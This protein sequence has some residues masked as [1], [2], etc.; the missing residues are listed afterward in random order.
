M[1]LIVLA[2]HEIHAPRDTRGH[3]QTGES[4]EVIVQSDDLILSTLLVAPTSR[5]APARSF[6]PTITI[7]NEKTQSTC[8]TNLGRCPRTARRLCGPRH[9]RRTQRNQRR[10]STCTRTR[11]TPQVPHPVPD[12]RRCEGLA[13]SKMDGMISDR[14]VSL[15]GKCLMTGSASLGAK[16]LSL[17]SV[18]LTGSTTL[19]VGLAASK[20]VV[21]L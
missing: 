5:S 19:R 8:R 12:R 4:F 3:E 21:C 20:S 16:T 17:G 6:R 1:T 13:C 15:V 11:L 10:T 14:M 18:R 2:R 7:N 9:A